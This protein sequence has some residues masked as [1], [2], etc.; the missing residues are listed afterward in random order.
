MALLTSAS[1]QWRLQGAR[2][3]AIGWP[4]VLV[5]AFPS[6]HSPLLSCLPSSTHLLFSLLLLPL[7]LPFPLNLARGLGSAVSFLSGSGHSP[8]AKRI[9]MH[10][11]IKK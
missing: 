4:E 5:R 6:F 2:V 8:A 7:P 9:L 10:F 3:G 1:D 11:K